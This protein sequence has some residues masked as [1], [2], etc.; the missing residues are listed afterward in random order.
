MAARAIKEEGNEHFKRKEY[1]KAAQCYTRAI[2]ISTGEGEGPKS[3]DLVVYYKNRAA[4]YLK[5]EHF[6]EAKSDCI[7]AL[8]INPNDPKSLYRY[9]QALEGTGNEAES[10]VQLKK[11]LKVD[12][13]NKEANEMARKLMISLKTAT[14][15]YQSTD[16]LVNE[17]FKRLSD[18][19]LSSDQR[20][21]AAKNLAILSREEGGADRI[22]RSGGVASLLPHLQDQSSELVNHVLQVYVGLV[23]GNRSRSE[24][25][26]NQFSLDKMSSHI[27]SAQPSIG[28]SAVA[29]LKEMVLS[30]TAI[31]P[32]ANGGGVGEKEA[33][34]PMEKPKETKT[35]TVEEEEAK[36]EDE[37]MNKEAAESITPLSPL[38]LPIVQLIF[39]SLSSHRVSSDTRDGLLEFFVKTVP[40]E[41]MPQLYIEQE[42]VKHVLKVAAETWEELSKE[43]LEEEEEEDR[44]P[45]SPECR[46][47]ASMVLSTLHNSIQGRHDKRLRELFMEQSQGFFKTQILQSDIQ[48]QLGLLSSLSCLLQGVTSLGNEIFSEDAILS[49]S[50]LMSESPDPTCQVAAAEAITLAAS[51]NTRCQGIMNKGLPAL[52]KLY[53]SSDDRIKVRALVGLCKLGSSSGGNVNKQP[54]AEGA[55][56]KL[57]KT[58]RRFLVSTKKGDNLRKWA[59]EGIAFLSL[60]AEVKE[61]LVKD[62]PALKVLFDLVKSSPDKS[63]L[64]G[65]A[66]I[67]VN[68]TNSYDK[69]E[70]N[71]ELE[72]LGKFAGENM[73]KEHEF[74]E[75]NYVKKRI[76]E[77]L[78]SKVVGMLSELTAATSS[79]A[80][81]EQ[82]SRVFLALVGEV[83]HRGSIV[84]QGG[85]KSLIQLS[86]DNNTDKGKLFAAQSLAKIGITS[87]PR[88]AFPGQ[89]SL[90][91]VRPLVKLLGFQSSGLQQFEGLMALTNLAS[92]SDDVRGRIV[93]EGAIPTAEGLMFEEDD[94]IRRAA[95]ELLCNMIQVDEVF[96]RFHGDDLERVKLWTLFSGEEDLGLARA[97]S[98]G[99][100]QLSHDKKICCKI[101][102]VKSSKDILKELLTK[103]EE[104]LLYRGLYILAN[105]IE[106]DQEIGEELIIKDDAFLE[107]LM[108]Y[109]Q[110][111]YNDKL[112]AEAKRALSKAMDY[113]LIQPNPQLTRD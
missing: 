87:D 112:K 50:I 104:D 95:T 97:A 60:D 89:R 71:P 82:A 105:L 14:D 96:E 10:L 75:P 109:V 20:T 92:T 49:L 2:E 98:G 54:F 19:S 45:V 86:L 113:G 18:L 69:P 94:L 61:E 28:M 3:D 46:M 78:K 31:P 106:A 51:D 93:R 39:I 43:E 64:Y 7:S 103:G 77:L 101:L 35:E 13:K 63:L 34:K 72:E 80:I 79:S 99:L 76:E 88:L 110:G 22:I 1:G 55:T 12:P 33:K 41:G 21:Q 36:K 100:A 74:D 85:V 44:L 107:I 40:R 23:S 81:R 16:S 48:S 47:N 38:V 9:A 53:H 5:Q 91:I 24:V 67:L 84:Q 30:L 8:K 32:I 59:A 26:F 73:P 4:C 90:E 58:C 108:A 25:V 102:E 15:R 57:E 70:R 37:K 42:L 56:L 66:S 11:L 27:N 68:L 52:K 111:D 65:I 29:I 6:S 83:S 17:M 62:G